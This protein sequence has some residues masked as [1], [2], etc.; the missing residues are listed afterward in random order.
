ME[1]KIGPKKAEN[2]GEGI[3]LQH[4]LVTTYLSYLEQHYSWALCIAIDIERDA[5][6]WNRQANTMISSRM[7]NL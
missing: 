4:P 6:S 5:L 1:I 3:R 7:M 2:N